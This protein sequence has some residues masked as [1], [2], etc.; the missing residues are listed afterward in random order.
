MYQFLKLKATVFSITKHTND[1][2]LFWKKSALKHKSTL[3]SLPILHISTQ[4]A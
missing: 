1:N 2:H 3:K 4:N